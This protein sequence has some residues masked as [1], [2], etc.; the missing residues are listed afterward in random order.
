MILV[1]SRKSVEWI[2]GFRADTVPMAAKILH[3]LMTYLIGSVAVFQ[4][5]SL[6]E[7]GE[8]EPVD[9]VPAPVA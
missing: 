1:A 6:Y 3:K 5:V 9:E 8:E 2:E 4:I 7:S